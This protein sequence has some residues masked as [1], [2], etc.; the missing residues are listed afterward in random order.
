MDG[1]VHVCCGV[2]V[3]DREKQRDNSATEG[4]TS[5][6]SLLLPGMEKKVKV[7][8]EVEGSSWS[9]SW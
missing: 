1:C 4:G 6:S 3:V 9:T 7:E 5:A 2:S 8:V